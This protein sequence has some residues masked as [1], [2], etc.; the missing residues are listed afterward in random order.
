MFPSEEFLVLDNTDYEDFYKH[1]TKTYQLHYDQKKFHGFISK[2]DA[3]QQWV[4]KVIHTEKNRYFIYGDKYGVELEDLI[5]KKYP[6]PFV[7][8]EITRTI[9]EACSFN[10]EIE[11]TANFRFF[12]NFRT[13]ECVFTVYTTFGVSFESKFL[14]PVLF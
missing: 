6:R 1:G 10:T 11:S 9:K 2:V 8:M 7:E 3:V 14:S 5:G 13:L 12:W 4:D